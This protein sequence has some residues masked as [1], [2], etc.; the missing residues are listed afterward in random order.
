MLAYLCLAAAMMIVGAYVGFSRVLVLAFPVFVLAWLRFAIAAVAMAHWLRRE[1]DAAPLDGH[2]R[3]LVFLESFLGNFLFSICMLYGMR[4]AT[5]IAAGVIM[6]GIPAAVALLS[7]LFLRERLAARTLAAIALAVTG[8]ATLAVT[9]SDGSGGGTSTL[10]VLLLLGA[11]F[12]EASYVVI[13][14]RLTG[15]LSPRRISALVNLWGFVLVTPFGL[16]SARSFDFG[17]VEPLWWGA[18]VL[19]ALAASMWTVW[20]W[21][22]GLRTVPAAKA[23]IFTVFLPLTSAAVGVVFLGERFSTTHLIAFAFAL[24]GVVLATWPEKRPTPRGDDD[25][26]RQ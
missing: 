10:G 11:L 19:Y 17:A 22:T 15:R 9:R 20:L 6:A 12:C 21:M 7:R 25:A 23:G 2:A 5:A 18:L 24:G 1:P 8:V 26:L 14:K 3:W 13:G 16:W 4:E